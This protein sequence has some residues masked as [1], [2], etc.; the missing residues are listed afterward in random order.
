VLLTR[1]APLEAV[2]GY[3]GTV[4]GATEWAA[5]HVDGVFQDGG[6]ERVDYAPV[7]DRLLAAGARATAS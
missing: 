4:L 6:F 7:V 3:G 2:N 5:T 1:G